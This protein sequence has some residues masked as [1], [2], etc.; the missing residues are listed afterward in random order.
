M[1][2]H[3]LASLPLAITAALFPAPAQPADSA[4]LVTRL[5]DAAAFDRIIAERGIDNL[6]TEDFEDSFAR[7]VPADEFAACIEPV[8]SHSNDA[9]FEPGGMPDGVRI[10]SGSRFGVIV[11]GTEILGS[12]SLVGGGWP[13]RLSPTS[14]NDTVL[15]FDD[16]PTVVSVDVFGFA[17]ESGWVV[18]AAPV[19]VELFDTAGTMIDAFEVQ[20]AA[21]GTPTSVAIDS[22]VPLGRIQIGADIPAAGAMIDNLVFG[23]GAGA[24]TAPGALEFGQVAAGDVSVLPVSLT[25]T[26]HLAA[27]VGTVP[28]PAAPFQLDDDDCSGVTL[29]PGASC[30]VW[31]AFEPAFADRF[32]VRV[33]VPALAPAAGTTLTL[34]GTGS[35][36][37][38]AQ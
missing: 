10:R 29:P 27:E 36:A 11:L 13:Y 33:E 32:E 2:L 20:G 12:D 30:T 26:G 22:K 4:P 34:T 7:F 9:C 19:M 24:L 28:A 35:L 18:G 5:P 25:N 23:G 3:L 6:R 21:S 37:G 17:I 8:G 15:E 38:G 31:I 16:G 1:K 14:I